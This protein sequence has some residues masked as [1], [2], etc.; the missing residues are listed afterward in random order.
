ML[1][2]LTIIVLTILIDLIWGELPTPIHPVVW[3]GKLIE[4]LSQHLLSLKTRTSGLLLTFTI[5][6]IFITLFY[7]IL[8]L[9]S[10][11]LL[12]YILIAA[13]ITSSTFAI[14]GLFKTASEVSEALRNDTNRARFLV[15]YL[16]SRD[17]THL[18]SEKLTSATV[19]SLTENINDS[20]TA[21]IFYI[22]MVYIILAGIL[23]WTRFG[24]T[25]VYLSSL[26]DF[27]GLFNH[28]LQFK[29]P[30]NDL[31]SFTL[32]STLAII[33]GVFYRV[34][35]TL[36]AMVGYKNEKYGLIGWFP[37][38]LDDILNYLPSR[39]TGFLVVIAALISGLDWR[40]SWKIMKRDARKPPSPNSG[41]TMAAAA[42]ALNVRLE[43]K[44]V[45]ILGDPKRH[46]NHE[47]IEEA[48]Y[49]TKITIALFLIAGF[50]TLII[51]SS[52]G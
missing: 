31:S 48:I 46:L 39:I 11:N 37:A 18:S 41:F 35:N 6:S 19:E 2:L 23:A 47:I 13:V 7:L 16:V 9:F 27:N 44:G 38:Y 21:P 36:D 30:I 15:S 45:Y 1:E 8:L 29:N 42:G 40:K 26:T 3:M 17:T 10:F 14:R 43:K 22:I 49:L 25:T 5:L 4:H 28:I 34:I 33:S 32:V 20:V 12:I 24:T 52:L 50:I 51:F